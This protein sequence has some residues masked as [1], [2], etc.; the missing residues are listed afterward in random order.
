MMDRKEGLQMTPYP[1]YPKIETLFER[2]ERTHKVDPT[3]WRLPEFSYLSGLDWRATEKVD[4]TNVRIC[5]D[6]HVVV[7]GGR[8][9]AAQ[10]PTFLLGV[11]QTIFTPEGLAKQFPATTPAS[12][13]VLYGEG[14]GAR[15]QKGGGLYKPDGVSFALFDVKVG[16]WWLT[17]ESI[18]D[19]AGK[20]GLNLVPVV[21]VVP[22]SRCIEL[23]RKGFKSAIGT[24]I[25]EGLVMR[26]LVP[27]LRR[28]S[29]RVIAKLK[30][31]D[32]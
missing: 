23:V 1:E 3:K 4:G 5:W 26:P 17:W 18:E 15:I 2:D 6:G 9:D 28:D 32:F 13:V 21:G 20:M 22:L 7:F 30:A 8:T 10:M 19:V 29:S 31:R 25:A 11:L 27:L 14:Y 12:P 24:A 16:E